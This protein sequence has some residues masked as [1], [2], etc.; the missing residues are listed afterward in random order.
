MCGHSGDSRKRATPCYLKVSPF[1]IEV[2]YEHVGLASGGISRL[3][4]AEKICLIKRLY[5]FSSLT[6]NVLLMLDG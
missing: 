3:F 4:M 5:R 1:Q 2:N 6:H